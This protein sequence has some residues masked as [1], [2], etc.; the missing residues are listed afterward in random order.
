MGLVMIPG[1]CSEKPSQLPDSVLIRHVGQVRG[2]PRCSP[3]H[4]SR[5]TAL[6]REIQSAVQLARR[7]MACLWWRSRL[8][9]N[10]KSD[11]K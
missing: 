8:G 6:A 7:E 9:G 11:S 3:S 5:R 2:G 1:R 10:S 4:R